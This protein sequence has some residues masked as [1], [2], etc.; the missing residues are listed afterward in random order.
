MGFGFVLA[1]ECCFHTENC[2]LIVIL[3]TEMNIYVLF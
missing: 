1:G 3:T 2:K